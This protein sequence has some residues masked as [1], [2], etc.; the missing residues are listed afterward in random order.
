MKK[1]LGDKR[2]LF[3][4]VF[5]A[6]IV[7][8]M[9]VFFP[10]LRSVYYSFFK[11]NP[12]LGLTYCGIEN[13]TRMWFDP[14]FLKSLSVTLK[15]VIVVFLG[16][17]IGGFSLALFLFFLI[18][19]KKIKDILRTITF[20]PVVL[21]IVAVAQIFSM[22]FEITPNYGLV[23]AI[24][25]SIG[26]KSLVQPWLGKE[27]SAF[28]I[29]CFMDIWR[30]VGF[31]TAIIYGALVEIPVELFECAVIDGASLSKIISNIVIP[32]IRSVLLVCITFSLV[33]TMRVF[34]SSLALTNGGPGTATRTLSMVMYD[35]AFTYMRYG[36]GSAIA[37]F[38][39][40]LC[41]LIGFILRRIDSWFRD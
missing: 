1:V 2:A 29:W 14:E 7:F 40:I 17:I 31:Y 6:L 12:G 21:P 28:W 5:P 8:L 22:M 34:E 30:G 3:I 9:F 33:G 11:G 24:F 16:H 13:Y 35:N 41:Y 20:L 37:V 10:V 25:N 26:L 23:N 19:S 39:F 36:Y 18:K 32:Y 27:S 4:F 38:L 15:Y